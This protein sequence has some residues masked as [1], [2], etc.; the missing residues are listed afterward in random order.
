MMAPVVAGS[1]INR[2][3]V[4]RGIGGIN[5]KMRRGGLTKD[6]AVESH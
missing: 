4:E 5:A 2:A 6:A 3:V 1:S